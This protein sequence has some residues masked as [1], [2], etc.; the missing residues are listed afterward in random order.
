MLDGDIK[1]MLDS[2]YSEE[3]IAKNVYNN[4]DKIA[5]KTKILTLKNKRN[6][7][8]SD[9]DNAQ[10]QIY[11]KALNMHSQNELQNKIDKVKESI[12]KYH[13]QDKDKNYNRFCAPCLEAF[14]ISELL[15]KKAS[16]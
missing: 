14:L 6:H 9:K 13:Q 10:L 7:H 4:Y 3:K 11:K 2:D 1:Q 8:G 15:E 5:I 12:K 16:Q